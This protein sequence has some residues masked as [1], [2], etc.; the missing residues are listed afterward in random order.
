MGGQPEQSCRPCAWKG[1][2]PGVTV[3]VAISKFLIH[4]FKQRTLNKGLCKFILLLVPHL[5]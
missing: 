3:C 1:L 2:E 5:M 4:I